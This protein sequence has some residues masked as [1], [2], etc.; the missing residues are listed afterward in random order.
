MW[1][2]ARYI[3]VEVTV[4]IDFVEINDFVLAEVKEISIDFFLS[5]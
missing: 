5:A 1:D 3:I 2:Y 4:I